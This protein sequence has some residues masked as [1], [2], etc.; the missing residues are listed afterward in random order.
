M[1]DRTT[2]VGKSML[3]F[4]VLGALAGA[5][6]LSAGAQVNQPPVV[7]I[8]SVPTLAPSATTITLN[9]AVADDGLPLGSAL[10]FQW[11]KI[12][13][14]GPVVFGSQ[15]SQSTTAF[16]DI[17]GTY[18]LR[19]QVSDGQLTGDDTVQVILNQVP[20]VPFV[21][22][23][24]I[25]ALPTNTLDPLFADRFL[26]LGTGATNPPST[27][28]GAYYAAID[29]A[30]QKTT[31]AAWKSAN[32]FSPSTPTVT[33]LADSACGCMASAV[34]GNQL[35]LGFGRRMVLARNGQ[36]VAFY[37]TNYADADD[38]IADVNPIL[39][40]CMEYST[41][42]GSAQRFTKFYTY[43]ATGARVGT[44]NFDNRGPKSMPE[45]CIACHGGA[46]GP[47]GTVPPFGNLGSSFLPFDLE[48]FEYSCLPGHSRADQER[49]FKEFNVAVYDTNPPE[50]IKEVVRGWYGG[51]G[52]PNA[53]Q[54]TGFI[55]SGWQD[56]AA[57]YRDVVAKS[58]RTCHL[59]RPAAAID[60][61]SSDDFRS[62]SFQA[63]LSNFVFGPTPSGFRMPHAIRTF[64]RFWNT[65][66]PHQP[67]V[68]SAALL[69]NFAGPSDPR[70][71]YVDPNATGAGTGFNWADAYTTLSAAL[72]AAAATPAIKEIWVADGVHKPSQA[73]LVDP[74]AATFSVPAGVSIYGGFRGR[75]I[76]PLTQNVSFA[77]EAN[78]SE[79]DVYAN[80]ASLSGDFFADDGP[81]F[82]GI[83]ENAYHVVTLAADA[84]L[85][86]FTVT[87]GNAAGAPVASGGGVLLSSGSASLHALTFV[88]NTATTGGALA[89]A[90]NGTVSIQNCRFFGNA[91]SNGG[92][93]S[94]AGAAQVE[95]VSTAFSGNSATVDGGAIFV[96]G[97]ALTLTN[98]TLGGN[99]AGQDAGGI[100]VGGAGQA[101]LRNTVLYGNSDAGGADESAQIF[102]A[103]GTV[104]AT[105]SI[106]QGLVSSFG[107]GNSAADPL[108]RNIAGCDGLAGTI[109][110]DLRLLAGSPAVDA[111][112]NAFLP[113]DGRDLDADGDPT[114]TVPFDAAGRRR[115]V[116]DFN[117]VDS[118]LGAQPI[119][120]LGAYELNQ[121]ALVTAAAGTVRLGS[122]G[123]ENILLVNNR[124]VGLSRRVDIARNAAVN[125]T[126]N[127]PTGLPIAPFVLF[128][129]LGAP[130]P[131]DAFTLFTVGTM[132]FRPAP[133]PPP[134]A[135]AFTLADSFGLGL[136]ALA[137][138]T[139]AP[140][141]LAAP[142]VGFEID[143][144]LQGV[145]FDPTQPM[146]LAITNAVLVRIT[147]ESMQKP[148]AA[149]SGPSNQPL[150]GL[151]PVTL[152]ASASCDPDGNPIVAYNWTIPT[153]V[154]LPDLAGLGTP[155]LT[156]TAPNVI[157]TLVFGLTVSDG[158][159]TS[160]PVQFVV[161]IGALNQPPTFTVGF[162][163]ALQTSVVLT[164]TTLS[165]IATDPEGAAV[166][167][168]W[169]YL[170]GSTGSPGSIALSPSTTSSSVQFTTPDFT[171]SCNLANL[172]LNFRVTAS[173]GTLSAIANVSV[174]VQKPTRTF[175]ADIMP[176]FT[177]PLP[178]GFKCSDCHNP[179]FGQFP[180]FALTGGASPTPRP[181]AN[182]YFDLTGVSSA[183]G[184]PAPPIATVYVNN[185]SP[186]SSLILNQPVT[187]S[188]PSMPS[189]LFDFGACGNA[190]GDANYQTML[191]WLQQ[192]ANF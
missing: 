24:I 159:E 133:L 7:S 19:L 77:G 126:V 115:R 21:V 110:D 117:V 8:P 150:V 81:G 130:E 175:S 190:T 91:A 66:S 132:A 164:T 95:L 171:A 5:P 187:G 108:F 17:A 119:V 137:A 50:S 136:P 30:G 183:N 169:Q 102:A 3:P 161:N 105:R 148:T 79:R 74:R 114:E 112:D 107:A 71:R 124:G 89:I 97:A 26:T 86:G 41:V 28:A 38:A 44:V 168:S 188:P 151:T 101:T 54:F 70:R 35:D 55:P 152:D 172:L 87:G 52:F 16:F 166:T 51:E 98:A 146:N 109:D 113:T 149:I 142:G 157:A 13:G 174:F 67:A 100:H 63:N 59:A 23:N 93:L 179:I 12:S 25:N 72:S 9:P 20:T 123:P 96:S 75:V 64:Q 84:R 14:P 58:C 27:T 185:G 85:D 181:A 155:I 156:F 163:P 29:P 170:G 33:N 92:A 147:D 49:P 18:T 82:T 135:R 43:G 31:L 37:V 134:D 11:C 39:T 154:A 65:T 116:D 88:A 144:A 131:T 145:V 106:V 32:G 139:P 48:S 173:D 15:W 162:P 141:S 57:L 40:V 192:G 180:F 47:G 140:W 4:W 125:I 73:G 83:V 127:P 189:C 22:N 111:G 36:D 61:A 94:S 1:S 78:L 122:G 143:F 160:D 128:G 176:I 6:V 167:Y 42:P 62:A 90:G 121:P 120:D 60:F 2:V 186:C 45:V 76:D 182:V 10:T 177:S 69:A 99:T 56:Q 191:Q 46:L 165:A 138:A 129:F 103:G 104:A 68:L 53:T 118:G 178:G 158:E 80:P 153:N 34:F 184:N